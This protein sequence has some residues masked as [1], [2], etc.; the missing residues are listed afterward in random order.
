V[1]RATIAA[2][3]IG[4]SWTFINGCKK[5][6]QNKEAVR[7]GV[8]TYLA[9]RSDLLAMDVNVTSVAFR[10]DEATATVQFQ[11]K[12]NNTPGGSMTMQYVLERKG[13]QWVVKGRGGSGSPH[14]GLPQGTPESPGSIGAMPQ[15]SPPGQGAAPTG[16]MPPGHPPVGSAKKTGK[17]Q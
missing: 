10:Q 12:G 16:A 15:I 3:L 1:K 2:A 9:K 6:I 11:A 17:D 5:D 13:E 4:F 14:T 8:M 7:Q